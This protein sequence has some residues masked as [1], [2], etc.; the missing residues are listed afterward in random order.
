MN[1]FGVKRCSQEIVEYL[2]NYEVRQR[3]GSTYANV[4]HVP[5]NNAPEH[6]NYVLIERDPDGLN[7]LN[8]T[9]WHRVFTFLNA[10]KNNINT[11]AEKLSSTNYFPL[12]IID[13]RATYH[14]TQRYDDVKD[15][16]LVLIILAD[17]LQ[18]VLVKEGSVRL[19]SHLLLKSVF[20]LKK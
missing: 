4:V 12:W 17:G 9:Q 10:R 14:L 18:R 11:N 5:N 13:T 8:D 3:C 7:G 6:A 19:G 1:V 15:K 2:K 16:T 20:S